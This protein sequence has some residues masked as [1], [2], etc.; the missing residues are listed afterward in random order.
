MECFRNLLE[1]LARNIRI[2]S[3][4]DCIQKSNNFNPFQLELNFWKTTPLNYSNLIIQICWQQDL[5]HI[6]VSPAL[7]HIVSLHLFYRFC[8]T[9]TY[10][11][12]YIKINFFLVGWILFAYIKK[13]CGH[14]CF[15]G[16]RA[17]L[18]TL[19]HKMISQ[20]ANRYFCMRVCSSELSSIVNQNDLKRHVVWSRR[21]CTHIS[22]DFD[23][24]N[25]D[26]SFIS[27]IFDS[28][29]FLVCWS[30]F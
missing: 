21:A 19:F 22:W 18:L 10:L 26:V 28:I 6:C 24:R 25:S 1:T 4:F 14:A 7:I 9:S 15:R 5:L 20:L 17:D 13:Y 8:S 16:K 12:H 2:K 3:F 30:V 27:I 29:I 11:L 23:T